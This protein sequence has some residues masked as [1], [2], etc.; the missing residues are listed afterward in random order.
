MFDASVV[1]PFIFLW[2]RRSLVVLGAKF[3]LLNHLVDSLVHKQSI[4]LK[5][6][7]R[8]EFSILEVVDVGTILMRNNC[9]HFLAMTEN[10]LG[11]GKHGSSRNATKVTQLPRRQKLQSD[12][13]G[14][15]F[16]WR[17]SV[18]GVKDRL[19]EQPDGRS[20][21][22]VICNLNGLFVIKTSKQT[23]SIDSLL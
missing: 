8:G 17:I 12:T 3:L 15:S 7:T 20:D 2:R 6:H 11:M 13:S 16:D 5:L 19:Q 4:V 21:M 1:I 9:K 14:G 18:E 22:V 23:K 10:N